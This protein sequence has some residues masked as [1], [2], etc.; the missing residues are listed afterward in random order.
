[1]AAPRKVRAT[2]TGIQRYEGEI[3][4]FKLQTEVPCRFKPG[5]F[6]HFAIDPYDPSFNWPES[7]VFSIANAPTGDTEIEILIS[8]KGTFTQR[9]IHDLQIG[10]E[11]WIKL[12]FGVFNFDSSIGK[13]VVLVAGGTGI[14]PFLSFLRSQLEKEVSCKSVQ[15]YYGVRNPGLIIFDGLLSECALNL[16]GF[17]YHIYCERGLSADTTFQHTGMLP[18]S[19][20]VKSTASSPS[21]VYY[22]SGPAAMIG[23]FEKEILRQGVSGER[24]I[25]DRWE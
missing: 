23:A 21:V 22:L 19:E 17:N 11:A 18:V 5:Q 7:R 14:S 4:L 13:D 6:L 25:Y 10:S 3:T 16:P 1:M 12:P 20:I 8:P 2:V 15:L 24:V 9:M